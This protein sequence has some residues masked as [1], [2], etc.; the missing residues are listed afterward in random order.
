MGRPLPPDYLLR[1]S[2]RVDGLAN[3]A[4]LQ[5]VVDEVGQDANPDPDQRRNEPVP[6][7]IAGPRAMRQYVRRSFPGIMPE[8][9]T[10]ATCALLPVPLCRSRLLTLDRDP[11][12]QRPLVPTYAL[13]LPPHRRSVVF[14]PPQVGV[15]RAEMDAELRRYRATCWT[16]AVAGQRAHDP[17]LRWRQCLLPSGEHRQVE[18]AW[19]RRQEDV[20]GQPRAHHVAQGRDVDA[21]E[22]HANTVFIG[23]LLYP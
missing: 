9:F 20:G 12:P 14:D 21:V 19:F 5:P 18:W 15:D 7:D 17:K 16:V 6:F 2:L 23:C 22:R 10:V 13:D 4:F 1:H 11:M 3:A 8:A